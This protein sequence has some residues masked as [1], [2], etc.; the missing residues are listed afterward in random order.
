MHKFTC[1]IMAA[2]YLDFD[3]FVWEFAPKKRLKPVYWMR[4]TRTTPLRS[5]TVAR[6]CVTSPKLPPVASLSAVWAVS[7]FLDMS[8]ATVW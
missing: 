3:G 5:V 8:A 1:M 6:H 2:L 4:T 7:M